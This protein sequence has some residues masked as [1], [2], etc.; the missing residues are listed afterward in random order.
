MRLRL[1]LIALIFLCACLVSNVANATLPVHQYTF[2]DGTANDSV[3]TAHGTLVGTASI[4]N[5]DNGTLVLTGGG[6]GNSYVDL[7]D[8]IASAASAGGVAGEITSEAWVNINSNSN[9]AVIFSFGNSGPDV[10]D[11]NGDDGDYWQLIPQNGAGAPNALRTTTHASAG[12][13][14]FA[15]DTVNGS[16]L[17]TG[18]LQHVVNVLNVGADT[19]ELYVNGV[20]VGSSAIQPGFDPNTY[21]GVGDTQ[22]WLGRSQWGDPS[23]DASYDEFRIYDHALSAEQ[24]RVNFNEGPTA[25]P[26]PAS[27][28]LFAALCVAAQVPLRR[29]VR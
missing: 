5:A 4:S 23:L 21:G 28:V 11:N 25:I 16:P 19:N 20:L 24:V 9:W 3:G 15:D 14:T 6:A 29:L 26:E 18:S 10:E 22:N 12:A 13:E 2:N 7:P 1:H 8:G 27:L 17:A